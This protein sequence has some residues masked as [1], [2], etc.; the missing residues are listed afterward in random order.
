[1][2]ELTYEKTLPK[3]QEEEVSAIENLFMYP[4]LKSWQSLG[5]MLSMRRL[6]AIS[7]NSS[8]GGRDTIHVHLNLKN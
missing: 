7:T 5:T 4:R 6:D 8:F 3:G 2:N 1:M